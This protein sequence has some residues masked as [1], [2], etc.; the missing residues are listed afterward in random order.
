MT[1]LITTF[2]LAFFYFIGAIP[3]GAA[4]G[5]PPPAAALAAWASYTAGAALV[6]WAGAPLRD[7]LMKRLKFSPEPKP[8]Q[9]IWRVWSRYGLLG[10]A[11]LAPV[12]VGSQ[13]GALIG[14]TLGV[15]APRLVGAMA[16]GAALWSA[17]IALAVA[18]GLGLAAS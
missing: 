1:A 7:W 13:M 14:L 16:L 9:L 8:E 5:L 2:T 15:P 3:A 12:T 17:G 18:L 10:L 4:L 6:A 11:A